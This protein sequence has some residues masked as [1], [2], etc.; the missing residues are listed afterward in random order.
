MNRYQNLL[1]TALLAGTLSSCSSTIKEA[2]K[3]PKIYSVS[4]R[5]TA[6]QPTYHRL[7]WVASPDVL[8]E[9]VLKTS[10]SSVREV[11]PIFHMNLK[12]VALDEAALVLAGTS[13]YTS[14]CQTTQCSQKVSINTLGTIDELAKQLTKTSGVQFFVDHSRREVRIDDSR[15]ASSNTPALPDFFGDSGTSQGE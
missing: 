2:P 3:D 15:I 8:P 5:Q 9:R 1:C 7:R 6:P 12:D 4:F 14:I 13:R 11:K 10:Q